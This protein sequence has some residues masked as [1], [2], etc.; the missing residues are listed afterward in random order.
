MVNG[1]PI[2]FSFLGPNGITITGLSGQIELQSAD[3]S[4][5]AENEVVRLANGDKMARGWY[6]RHQKGSIEAIVTG[7]GMAAAIANTTVNNY[8]PGSF[9]VVTRCDSMPD[10]VGKSWEVQSGA[11]MAGSNTSAKRLTLPV[12]YNPN[13]TATA[14]P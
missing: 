4:A 12:E 13:I 9:C 1:Y 3:V 10:L 5:E 6:D 11:R 2:N 8:L 7:S 14:A